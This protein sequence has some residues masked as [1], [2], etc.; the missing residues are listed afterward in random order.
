MTQLVAAVPIAG[1]I[2]TASCTHIYLPMLQRYGGMAQNLFLLAISVSQ[3][4]GWNDISLLNDAITICGLQ[5]KT[6]PSRHLILFRR[7]WGK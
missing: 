6:I 2:P 7:L 1:L 5:F 4:P 3:P